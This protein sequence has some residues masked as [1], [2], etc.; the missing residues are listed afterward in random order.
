MQKLDR[1]VALLQCTAYEADQVEVVVRQAVDLLGGMS[2]FVRPGQRVLIKPN[3]LQPSDPAKAIITHPMVVRA[4][5]KLVQE[6][7]G[8]AFIAD[9]P[10]VP[11]LTR[12]G[13]IR[14]YERA[15]WMTVA[16]ETGAELNTQVIP[17]QRSHPD[18]VLIKL[19][20]TSSFLTE[21]DVVISVPKLK[22]H[23]FMRFT[24]AVK[25]LFGTVPGTIKSG[26]HVKLQVADRFADMLLDLVR[27]VRPALTVMDAVVSMDGD[28]PSA[29]QPFPIGAILAASD[30]VLLDVVALSLV[31]HQPLS[32]AT[33]SR[34]RQRGWIT[35]DITDV[36]LRGGDLASMR[37]KGFRLPAGRRSDVDFM[38]SFL[39][40]FGTQL[41][42]SNPYVTERCT[43]C[44]LCIESCPVQTIAQVG[45]RAQIYLGNCIRCYCCHEGCP[46][47]AIE[48]RQPWLGRKLASMGR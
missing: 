28:G 42:V 14:A 37:V 7:G 25:N 9:N 34:A 11:P 40:R 39:R 46:E 26:Y 6:A 2:R 5:V 43:G 32:V 33:V 3:L 24:G 35:G 38:P 13:W 36:E 44:N 22:T 16:A 8:S 31:G 15:G 20:D 19:V 18:G 41:L 1:S 47:H 12:S 23:G 10:F 48:L 27:F 45:D 21:A 4:V 30:P 29:G 17:L